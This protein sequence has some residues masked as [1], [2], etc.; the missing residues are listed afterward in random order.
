M[1]IIS[2][3][4]SF[5]NYL[6]IYFHFLDGLLNPNQLYSSNQLLQFL[7]NNHDFLIPK[8]VSDICYLDFK[9]NLYFPYNID[10]DFYNCSNKEPINIKLA[11]TGKIFE[12]HGLKANNK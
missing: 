12:G 6:P 4:N 7:Y 10:L 9:Q 3:Q 1:S 2:F 11:P 8:Q 5:N